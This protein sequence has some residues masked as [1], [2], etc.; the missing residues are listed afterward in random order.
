MRRSLSCPARSLARH[1]GVVV[2]SDSFHS[3]SSQSRYGD[4]AASGVP[5]AALALATDC[6][7]ADPRRRPTATGAL[8]HVFFDVV[9]AS[10]AADAAADGGGA[11]APSTTPSSASARSLRRSRRRA[12]GDGGSAFDATALPLLR[13]ARV[14]AAAARRLAHVDREA[15]DAEFIVALEEGNDAKC[16]ARGRGSSSSPDL[17]ADM[18]RLLRA[19]CEARTR[20]T[21]RDAPRVAA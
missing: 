14:A 9:D 12:G 18:A 17:T 8:A 20:V 19:L 7:R 13:R 10:D 15:F 11:T 1:P 16:G 21:V 3:S 5:R 2:R 4:A 6:L